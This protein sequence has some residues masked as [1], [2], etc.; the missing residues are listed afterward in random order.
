MYILTMKLSAYLLIVCILY[1]ILV[2]MYIKS[3]YFVGILVKLRER[4]LISGPGFSVFILFPLPA[5]VCSQV[6]KKS[7]ELCSFTLRNVL[8]IMV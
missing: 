7:Q 5:E 8:K 6:Q 3:P 2:Q 4:K 1:P